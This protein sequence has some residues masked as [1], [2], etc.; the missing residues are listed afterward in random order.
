MRFRL[1]VEFRV[2]SGCLL[3]LGAEAK[4]QESWKLCGGDRD[5]CSSLE[6]AGYCQQMSHECCGM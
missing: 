2:R 4:F 6:V 1:K 3:N 5:G